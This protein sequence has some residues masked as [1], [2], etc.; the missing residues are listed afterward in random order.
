M[1]TRFMTAL[2]VYACCLGVWAACSAHEV[3]RPHPQA[4]GPFVYVGPRAGWQVR[5]PMP[6]PAA[7]HADP[8]LGVIT[9]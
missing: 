9:A 7:P 6:Y 3:H 1:L 5:W 8:K 2:A 4:H